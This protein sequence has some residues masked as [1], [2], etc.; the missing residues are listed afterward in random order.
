MKAGSEGRIDLD[1]FKHSF[2][3]H[4]NL[5][6]ACRAC[7]SACPSGVEYSHLVEQTRFVVEQNR[8]PGIS[9][10]FLRWLGTKQGMPHIRRLKLI[11]RLLY[12]YQKFGLQKFLRSNYILPEPLR[13]MES[14]LPPLGENFN[15]FT[16]PVIPLGEIRGRVLFFTGCIQEGFLPQV[17]RATARGLQINGYEVHV[18]EQ[19]TCCGAAHLHLGDI[20]LA[21]E[22]AKQN[23]DAFLNQGTDFDRIID[24]AVGCG[25]SLKE[26]PHLLSEDPVYADKAREFASKIFDVNEFLSENLSQAPEGVLDMRATY[27]DS[28]H[29]RHGQKVIDQ[30]RM[31]LK[32][33]PGLEFVELSSPDQCCG[34]AGV[35][36]VTQVDTA[37]QILDAK[38]MD[39]AQTGAELIVTSNTGCQMQ[40]IA[41]VRKAGL[42]AKVLHVVE[43]LDWSYAKQ[44]IENK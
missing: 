10:R 42:E 6:L 37:N 12:F 41:G 4:I 2:T 23:I 25:V 20:E 21:K 33:I 24:N 30:P 29:L 34:S 13:T 5:C 3:E 18:P 32:L 31:L 43:V 11:S 39:I 8:S 38:M 7:E 44:G 14:I 40:L 36:N 17:N 28:C 15:D 1:N 19:Q 9:E 26:Y 35:Y 22:L 27:S 16:Q